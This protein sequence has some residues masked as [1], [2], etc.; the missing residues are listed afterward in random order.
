[1][2]IAY[3]SINRSAKLSFAKKVLLRMKQG[4]EKINFMLLFIKLCDDTLQ[5]VTVDFLFEKNS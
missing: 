1:M 5:S 3:H 4:L 2:F